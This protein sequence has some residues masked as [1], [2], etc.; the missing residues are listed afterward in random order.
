MLS[1]D[2]V[3]HP[4]DGLRDEHWRGGDVHELSDRVAGE[5]G[6]TGAGQPAAEYAAP[7]ADAAFP[8]RDYSPGLAAVDVPVVGDVDESSSDDPADDGVDG[9]VVDHVGV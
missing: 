1:V 3:A 8:D 2:D 9:E 5:V 6:V 7:E 4:A